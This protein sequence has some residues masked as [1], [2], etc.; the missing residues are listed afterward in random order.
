MEQVVYNVFLTLMSVC[1]LRI[2]MFLM[3]HIGKVNK[4]S[5]TFLFQVPEED[6]VSVTDMLH[7]QRNEPS[8]T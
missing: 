7:H 4:S 5:V 6:I 3:P 2:T 8:T 1:I